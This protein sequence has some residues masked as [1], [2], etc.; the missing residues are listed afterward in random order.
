MEYV[1]I[2]GALFALTIIVRRFVWNQKMDNTEFEYVD[3]EEELFGLESGEE[4]FIIEIVS[5][6]SIREARLTVTGRLQVFVGAGS[7]YATW[8]QFP[9]AMRY[10]IKSP[11]GTI[12]TTFDLTLSISEDSRTY[13]LY[14]AEPCD[15]IV[16][17]NFQ[18]NAFELCEK[19]IA[20]PGQYEVRALYESWS[21]NWVTVDVIA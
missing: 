19:W 6:V 5:P 16:G 3:E 12:G 9:S 20:E 7:Q 15:Q 21:S 10:E 1:I 11:D 8:R 14:A 4:R 18:T 2:A 13:D 17:Q